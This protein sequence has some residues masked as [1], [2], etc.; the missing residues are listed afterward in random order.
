MISELALIIII[1]L[2]LGL[3]II[4]QLAKWLLSKRLKLS[5]GR[6]TIIRGESMH[7]EVSIN[8]GFRTMEYGVKA[9]EMYETSGKHG[10]LF[11]EV[12]FTLSERTASGSIRQFTH[13]F[14]IPPSAPPS[15]G[16]YDGDSCRRV[17]LRWVAFA[18][19]DV[20][21]SPDMYQEAEFKVS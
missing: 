1:P 6:K 4:Y 14:I 20:P 15:I 11:Q 2:A 16:I 5:L 13:D 17:G 10:R 18:K 9:V 12:A 19:V 21:N 8:N 7:L 3:P